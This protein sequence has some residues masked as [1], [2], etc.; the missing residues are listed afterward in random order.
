[1]TPLVGELALPTSTPKKG[2]TATWL[3]VAIIAIAV[4]MC[5]VLIG[6]L[7]WIQSLQ[8]EAALVEFMASAAGKNFF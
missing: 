8:P 6:A 7:A 2:D 3:W 1:M 5:V 4:V